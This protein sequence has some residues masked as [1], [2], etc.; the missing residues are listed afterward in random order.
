VSSFIEQVLGGILP[1][2]GRALCRSHSIL[3][4]MLCGSHSIFDRMLDSLFDPGCF[5]TNRR[6]LCPGPYRLPK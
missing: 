3:N 4:R 6:N 1:S 2:F 5:K